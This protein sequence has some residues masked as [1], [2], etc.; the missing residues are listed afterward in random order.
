[1]DKNFNGITSWYSK[2]QATHNNSFIFALSNNWVASKTRKQDPNFLH[3]LC[4]NTL[5]SSA[6]NLVVT[7]STAIQPSFDSPSYLH[8]NNKKLRGATEKKELYV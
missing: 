5:L 4:F 1:M 7:H 8:I 2:I 3:Y 6:M